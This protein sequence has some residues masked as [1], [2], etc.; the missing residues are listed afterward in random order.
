VCVVPAGVHHA[1]R[2]P[3]ELGL[4]GGS[5]GHVRPLGDRQAVHIG[6]EADHRSRLAALQYADDTG[7]RDARAHLDAHRPKLV[8]DKLG[9]GGLAVAQFR[10]CV[11]EAAPLDDL[12]HHP[13]GRG[14]DLAAHVDREDRGGENDERA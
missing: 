1:D 5:E 6:A 13:N 9:S 2:L 14:V 7:F 10:V 12:R 11:D 3:V 4:D 8:G